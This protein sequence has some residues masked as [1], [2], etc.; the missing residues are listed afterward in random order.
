[1]R[2]EYDF[3]GAVRAKYAARLSEKER[4]ELRRRSAAVDGHYW[5]GHTLRR[6]Q[7]LE[8]MVVAYLTLALNRNP[9]AAGGEAA[10]LLEG[11]D[12]ASLARFTSAFARAGRSDV[13]SRFRRVMAERS[14]LIHKGGFAVSSEQ[15]DSEMIAAAVRRLE[16]TARDADELTQGLRAS[17]QERLGETGLSSEEVQRRTDEVIHHWLAA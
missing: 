15:G 14:W 12:V 7:E 1:M 16:S 11:S 3:S 5:F 4:A 10:A 2:P 8:A 17:L 6:I 9:E 13:E